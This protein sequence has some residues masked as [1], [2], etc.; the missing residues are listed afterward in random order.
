MINNDDTLIKSKGIILSGNQIKLLKY[1][2]EK[3]VAILE[4]AYKDLEM[5]KPTAGH[6]IKQL[7]KFGLIKEVNSEGRT[8]PRQLTD[9]GEATYNFLKGKPIS[10]ESK[11]DFSALDMIVDLGLTTLT[12]DEMSKV[13]E[14]FK[15]EIR[16]AMLKKRKIPNPSTT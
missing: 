3:G 9:L 13:I 8:K 16:E 2:K 7:E 6:H 12:Q 11:L 14:K 10:D 15:E 5:K 4:D 1:F